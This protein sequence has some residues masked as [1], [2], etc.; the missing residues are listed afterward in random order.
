[1]FSPERWTLAYS[2][3]L[4]APSAVAT[5][6]LWMG[7]NRVL[8]YNAIF[9]S[10][11]VLSGVGAALLVRR[12]TGRVPAALV[13]GRLLSL[14]PFSFCPFLPFRFSHYPQLQLQQA[15]WIPLSLWA[16]HRLLDNGRLS[17]GVLLGG[18]IACQLLSCMYYGVYLASYVAIVGGLLWFALRRF[19]WVRLRGIAAARVVA[20]ALFPP[21]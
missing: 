8:V 3:T 18:A 11:F 7:V 10:G 17:D 9:L 20:I 15:E 19:D 4:L 12:L 5:P 13:A 6:L 21:G 16:Y 14:F 2:E 1:I